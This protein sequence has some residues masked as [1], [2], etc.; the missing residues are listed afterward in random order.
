MIAPEDNVEDT[1]LPGL[2]AEDAD[3]SRVYALSVAEL[4]AEVPF[5]VGHLD[6]LRAEVEARPDTRLVVIDPLVSVVS[7]SGIDDHRQTEVRRVLDPL[8]H[9]AEQTGV[10]VV[11]VCHLNKAAAETAIDKIA[12]SR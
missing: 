12:G 5:G 9:F 6:L 2:A 7:R 8:R 1:L 3:L 10:T 11:V 4:G